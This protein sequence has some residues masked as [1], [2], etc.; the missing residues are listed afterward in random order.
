MIPRRNRGAC[1]APD[2]LAV[3]AD[4]AVADAVMAVVM[5]MDVR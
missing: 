3:T 2:D 4:T 5:E 1:A